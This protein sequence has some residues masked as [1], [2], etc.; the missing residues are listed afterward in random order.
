MNEQ[1]SVLMHMREHAR[2]ADPTLPVNVRS[3]VYNWALRLY[4]T[5]T[6]RECNASEVSGT[7]GGR[8]ALSGALSGAYVVFLR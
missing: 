4:H 2:A 5:A 7:G 6:I 1:A 3:L 8:E